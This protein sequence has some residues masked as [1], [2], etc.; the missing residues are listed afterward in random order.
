MQERNIDGLLP[1]RPDGITPVTFHFAEDTQPTEPQWS[2]LKGIFLNILFYFIYF[3]RGGK[4]GRKRERNISVWLPLTW[5]P[6]GTWPATQA[7]CPDW[8]SNQQPFG[9][10]PTLN[11]LSNTS[12]G[13]KW[14]IFIFSNRKQTD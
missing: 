3:E 1:A 8:E 10:Q 13:L 2:G 5:P 4:R 6:L 12:Q 9:L 14:I 7:C 11:P